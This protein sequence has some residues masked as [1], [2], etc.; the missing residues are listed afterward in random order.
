VAIAIKR[1]IASFCFFFCFYFI[2]SNLFRKTKIISNV[3]NDPIGD[4]YAIRAQEEQRLI[5][6]KVCF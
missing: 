1:E 5:R 4:A 6:L 3:S 2:N